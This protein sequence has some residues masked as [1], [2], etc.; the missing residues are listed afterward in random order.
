MPDRDDILKATDETE[1]GFVRV[2]AASALREIP[3]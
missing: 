3:L 2:K 1:P